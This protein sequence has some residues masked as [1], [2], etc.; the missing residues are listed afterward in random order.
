MEA[1]SHALDQRRV[2]DIEFDVGIFTNLT[3]DHLDYHGDIEHYKAAKKLL[4]E[5][6]LRHSSKEK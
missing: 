3:H 6:Y 1:S 4:F 5:D 2:E